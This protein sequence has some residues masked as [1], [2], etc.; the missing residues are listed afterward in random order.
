MPGDAATGA[1]ALGVP[2]VLLGL[3][4]VVR[5]RR[6]DPAAPLE[7]RR[8]RA[9]RVLRRALGRAGNPRD[10]H[11]AFL[12]FL[13]A[14]TR[15]AGGAWAGRSAVGWNESFPPPRRPL[16]PEAA[17]DLDRL[18]RRLEAGVFGHGEAVP[19]AELHDRARKLVG[20]GF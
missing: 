20:G 16:D 19:T 9:P 14:R 4:V 6:G 13:C 3:R 10:E 8:R 15:E 17:A 7:R 11:D 18:L 1:I 2:L 5:R 12:A